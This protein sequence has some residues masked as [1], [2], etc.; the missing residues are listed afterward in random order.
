MLH[1]HVLG[2]PSNEIA[3][4]CCCLC[5]ASFYSA[6]R[7]MTSSV[8]SA[9]GCFELGFV[10]G[11]GLWGCVHGGHSACVRMIAGQVGVRVSG[12][13]PVCLCCLRPAP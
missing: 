6:L 12:A 3:V 4:P 11:P 10:Q 1:V 8:I 13:L 5:A 9:M 7:P 2:L